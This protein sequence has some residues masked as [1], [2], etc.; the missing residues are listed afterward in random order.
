VLEVAASR[1]GGDPQV[2]EALAASYEAWVV[3]RGRA[4]DL[5]AAREIHAR[6]AARFPDDPRTLRLEA[7]LGAGP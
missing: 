3:E 6:M 4:G 5:R 7:A 1:L 2:R